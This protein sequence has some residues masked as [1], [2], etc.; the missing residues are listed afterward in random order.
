M[1]NDPATRLLIEGIFALYV[2]LRLLHHHKRLP[3]L[4]LTRDLTYC[5]GLVLLW[6]IELAILPDRKSDT[7]LV[8]ALA[9]G[10]VAIMCSIHGRYPRWI[11]H[12]TFGNNGLGN[13]RK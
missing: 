3:E 8:L 12:Q 2:I 7:H 10:V 6:A 5:S 9:R 4:D 13:Q 1:A 11:W